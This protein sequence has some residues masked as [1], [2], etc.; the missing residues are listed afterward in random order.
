M[1]YFI[2]LWWFLSFLL[3]N[4]KNAYNIY[5]HCKSIILFF[6]NW[7]KYMV[8]DSF[9]SSYASLS[10]QGQTN[11]WLTGQQINSSIW[12]T[13]FPRFCCLVVC[14]L[15]PTDNWPN[16]NYLTSCQNISSVANNIWYGR[17]LQCCKISLDIY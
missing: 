15:I 11:I 8:K 1:D 7:R 5:V 6:L 2:Y 16:I 10:L 14:F 13:G 12:D 9:N 4:T 3:L 17:K